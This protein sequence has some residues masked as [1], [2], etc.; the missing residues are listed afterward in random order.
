M[1]ITVPVVHGGYTLAAKK[2]KT[3][4]RLREMR[5]SIRPVPW[6]DEFMSLFS[7]QLG[8]S[9]PAAV[10]NYRR[11]ELLVEKTSSFSSPDDQEGL[12][13]S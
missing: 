9:Q 13:Y 11:P 1:T 12:H 3:M 4:S 2:A 6:Y 10:T 8:C 5:A 7:L